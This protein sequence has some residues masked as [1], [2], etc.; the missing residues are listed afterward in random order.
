MIQDTQLLPDGL[1]P[2]VPVQL[3]Y[4]RHIPISSAQNGS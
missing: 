4:C 2:R 3:S 1:I